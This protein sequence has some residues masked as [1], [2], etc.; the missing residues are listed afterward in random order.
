MVVNLLEAKERVK[1]RNWERDTQGD[2][3]SDGLL[4]VVHYMK[5]F[6]DL[7]LILR[8]NINQ[9]KTLVVMQMWKYTYDLLP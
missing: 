7:F 8:L 2:K 4:G 6:L 5:N 9:K 1:E 3:R